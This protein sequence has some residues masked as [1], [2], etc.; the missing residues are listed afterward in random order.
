M[1]FIFDCTHN[2]QERTLS[3][4]MLGIDNTTR[5]A[6]QEKIE[7]LCN[8][9]ENNKRENELKHFAKFIYESERKRFENS[10]K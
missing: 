10:R 7:I 1:H 2:Q 3:F 6:I 9:L 8:I 5:L 4:N